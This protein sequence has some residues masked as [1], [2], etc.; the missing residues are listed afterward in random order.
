MV[1]FLLRV[2]DNI[3]VIIQILCFIAGIILL[4]WSLTVLMFYS[5]WLG[6]GT[7]L[8]LISTIS[9]ILEYDNE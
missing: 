8:I 2:L 6:V 9:A 7:I 5:I 4:F 1:N 3:I